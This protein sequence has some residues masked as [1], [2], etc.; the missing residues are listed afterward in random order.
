MGKLFFFCCSFCNTIKQGTFHSPIVRS[1][2]QILTQISS[3]FTGDAQRSCSHRRPEKN[4]GSVTGATKGSTCKRAEAVACDTKAEIDIRTNVSP[5]CS[6]SYVTY[7]TRF[8]NP[9]LLTW[10]S[11]CYQVWDS[12][13]VHQKHEQFFFKCS[14]S[15][16]KIR[17]EGHTSLHSETMILLWNAY[18][19]L[20]VSTT[21]SQGSVTSTNNWKR[22]LTYSA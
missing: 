11:H 3:Q 18:G 7:Q 1:Q 5:V 20:G 21:S 4:W 9:R 2:D 22:P 15:L 16:G 6:S 10:V 12:E 14:Q 8:P 17:S 19:A 13:I